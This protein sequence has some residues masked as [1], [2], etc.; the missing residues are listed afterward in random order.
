MNLTVTILGCG[1]SGGVPRVGQGWGACDPADPRNRRRRCS[2]LVE[3]A[4]TDGP[5]T[6]LLV[7]TSPDL[8]DQLLDANVERLDGIVLTHLHADH[9]HGIDDLRPLVIHMRRRIP[10][11]MD[12]TTAAAV[13]HRFSYVF[14]TPPG[15]QYPPLC[16]EI[17]I[18][19]D[20]TF[21]IPGPGD[22]MTT[23]PFR[24]EHGDIDALGLRIGAFAYTPD[25]AAFPAASLRHLEGLDLWIVDALRYARHPSH[26]S[27]AET[28]A[29]I[30]RLKPRRAVLTNLHTDLDYATL[31]AELPANVVPAYDGMRLTVE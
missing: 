22:A 6:T 30:D 27:L 31:A 20:G 28:L 8:R 24:V 4:G 14:R 12:E 18:V 2:I 3:Q 29:W 5:A 19:D 13:T 10:V 1:S 11:Y 15:S 17:R 7:D 23:T 21:A 9:T 26:L 16:D 25:V